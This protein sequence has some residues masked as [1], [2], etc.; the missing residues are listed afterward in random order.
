MAEL[1]ARGAALGQHLAVRGV[2]VTFI[3]LAAA[4]L[5]GALGVLAHARDRLGASISLSNIDR[6]AG[7]PELKGA[8]SR[9]QQHLAPIV[10]DTLEHLN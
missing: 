1:P 6:A 9:I 3:Q 2:V 4:G 8:I 7:G 10:G 5:L